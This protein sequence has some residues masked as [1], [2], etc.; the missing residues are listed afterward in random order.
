[1][2]RW[3]KLTALAVGAVVSGG[4]GEAEAMPDEEVAEVPQEVV[5]GPV[6]GH[7]MSP[8][9]TGRVAVGTM[10]PDFSAVSL[11]GPTFTLSSL[12]GEKNVVLFFYR[13]HW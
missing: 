2:R 8:T 10:A 5:L 12:R 4:C 7:D 6:D 9:D 13:G 3:N 1:M 11:A